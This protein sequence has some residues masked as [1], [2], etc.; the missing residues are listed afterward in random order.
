MLAKR[1]NTVTHG[2][3]RNGIIVRREDQEILTDKISNSVIHIETKQIKHLNIPRYWH[4]QTLTFHA[5]KY[6][7][8]LI[9][10]Y[11]NHCFVSYSFKTLFYSRLLHKA[12]A[13]GKRALTYALAQRFA[14]L[15]KINE[16][17]AEKRVGC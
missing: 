8:T 12:V 15:N 1:N 4:L 17:D 9:L 10:K 16:K 11:F 7:L 3:E 13:Q 14:T 6:I 5:L 2:E